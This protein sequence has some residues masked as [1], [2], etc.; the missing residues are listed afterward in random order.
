[1]FWR[2]RVLGWV[3]PPESAGQAELERLL[4][5]HHTRLNALAHLAYLDRELP[6]P[7]ARVARFHAV[8]GAVEEP[9]EHTGTERDSAQ[10]A[11]DRRFRTAM[12]DFGSGDGSPEAD[13]VAES[14]VE[15]PD[16]DL[17]TAAELASHADLVRRIYLALP[18]ETATALHRR[19]RLI[20]G[21]TGHPEGL[22]A[23]DRRAQVVENIR[24]AVLGELYLASR[25]AG[26]DVEITAL[27]E[28]AAIALSQRL[29]DTFTTQA[30][31]APRGLRRTGR[32]LPD[33]R[34]GPGRPHRGS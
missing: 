23:S 28:S 1:V 4:P 21:R 20:L 29:R 22:P 24:Y 13:S 27:D 5:V 26:E 25:R 18:Q 32:Q 6:N 9:P 15:A 10:Q 31:V 33:S 16:A 14:R 19:S 34:G 7:L 30:P 12:R 2:H 3:L 17:A 11:L 8:S